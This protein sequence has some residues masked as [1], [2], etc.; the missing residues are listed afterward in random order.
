MFGRGYGFI[1]LVLPIVGLWWL[2]R[3]RAR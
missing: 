2:Q 1:P 3:T